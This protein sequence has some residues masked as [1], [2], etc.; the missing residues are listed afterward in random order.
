MENLNQNFWDNISK[1]YPDA[2]KVFTDWLDGYKK[3]NNWDRLFQSGFITCR[4]AYDGNGYDV[5][6]ETYTR[7]LSE[8]PLAMQIGIMIEFYIL[9][10]G[11]SRDILNEWK[12]EALLL[13]NSLQNSPESRDALT[14]RI[15]AINALGAK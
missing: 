11:K 10:D 3:R 2:S 15:A 7:E 5:T 9:Y 8:I 6:G 12:T 13:F 14:D 1:E 4:R